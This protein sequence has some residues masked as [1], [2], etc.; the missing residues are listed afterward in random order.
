MLLVL[1]LRTEKAR[2][3]VFLEILVNNSS[4]FF[5][6]DTFFQKRLQLSFCFLLRLNLQETEA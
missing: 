3:L 1:R 6:F 4:K 5:E 2:Q